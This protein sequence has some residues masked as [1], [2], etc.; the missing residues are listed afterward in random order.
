MM[1]KVFIFL[2][3]V[4]LL[5]L[6][7]P[8]ATRAQGYKAESAK[9]EAPAE[10]AADVRGT[11]SDQA[12]KI[13]NPQGA[14]CEI[15]LR[16]SV[17]AKAGA[18]TAL[19]V[20]YPQFT[21]GELVGAIR[22]DADAKDYRKQTVKPGVFTLRYMLIPVDGN[23]QGVAPNRDFLLLVPGAMDASAGTLAPPDLIKA[24]RKSAGTGHPSV[25]SLLDADSAPAAL[26]GIA[27]MADGDLW[28]VYFNL[29]IATDGGGAANAPMA[30][31]IAGYAPES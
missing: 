9:A 6:C 3:A 27:H 26:P 12:I 28:V 5:L 21:E 1:K 24:S 11:L 10:L 29:P 20:I 16:K 23:H 19:G 14:L 25:W 31:V 15:W 2:S 30:L 13:S 4:F 8:G 7:T 17:P 18:A 22:F